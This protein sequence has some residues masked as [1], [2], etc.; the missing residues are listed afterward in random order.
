MMK[1][2]PCLK[3][4]YSKMIDVS[5]AGCSE[6]TIYEKTKRKAF[7]ETKNTI[8]KYKDYLDIE[9][10]MELLKILIDTECD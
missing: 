2:D 8:I 3:C 7:T 10:Q 1:K 5:C 6:K 9:E 4:A